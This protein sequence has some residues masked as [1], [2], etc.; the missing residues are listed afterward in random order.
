MRIW[1]INHYAVPPKY[2]PLARP[3]LFAKNLIK[4]GNEVRIIAASTV[5]NSDSKNLINGRERV[6]EII[7]DGIPY[8]LI[9]CTPYEGNGVDRIINILQFAKR[10]PKILDTFE[11]PDAIVATSFDP[12]SCYV[13]IKY[14]KKN[15]IKAIAEIADL[16]PETLIA[17][18]GV[19]PS[20]PFV[21]YLRHIEKNIYA[22]SDAVVF[23]AAGGYDYIVEQGW[24]K[25]FPKSKF[26]YIN[27]GID[28][29]QFDSNKETYKVQDVDLENENIFK[30][31]YTGS[32]RK[33]NAVGEILDVAKCIKNERVKFLIWGYGDEVGLIRK[34]IEEEKIDN[35]IYKGVVEKKYVPYITSRADLN[36]AHNHAS[37]LFK[38]GISFNK[39]FDY[40]A[41]GKPILCDFPCR[42]NPVLMGKAGISV[43]SADKEEIAAQIENFAK[44]NPESY[45]NYSEA[46][47][48]TAAEYDFKYLTNKLVKIIN[49][50]K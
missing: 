24:E 41:A 32:I 22:R 5:H 14:A 3:S 48:K 49:S 25:E 42:Y 37:P 16:W 45:R 9:N 4:L 29:E 10:L 35:V 12:L 26:H 20:N 8:L 31:I 50:I 27:N 1:I 36:Y 21:K 18:K 30:V 13:G 47:R 44:M 15:F 39:I 46:A 17:Y 34:R 40:L 19:S 11:K 28:L 23:T 33:V 38:Y 43:E 7:D 2:Y 6:K